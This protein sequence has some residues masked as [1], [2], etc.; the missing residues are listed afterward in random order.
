MENYLKFENSNKNLLTNIIIFLYYATSWQQK[1]IN[2]KNKTANI[3]LQ[4]GVRI[5]Q[6]FSDLNVTQEMQ[7]DIMT[8][9]NII[10]AA[11]IAENIFAIRKDFLRILLDMITN[12]SLLVVTIWSSKI[13]SNEI[14]HIL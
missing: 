9:L 6:Y 2:N 14:Y 3:Y 4:N 13:T 11:T 7:G 5:S 12:I 8:F 10:G 1:T